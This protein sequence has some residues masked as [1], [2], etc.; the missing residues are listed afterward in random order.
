MAK[1][2]DVARIDKLAVESE[3]A[4]LDVMQSNLSFM[5]DTIIN[6]VVAKDSGLRD[7]EKLDAIKGI[8]A[9]G[10][11]AYKKDLLD[12]LTVIAYET[13]RLTKKE[14]PGVKYELSENDIY[15]VQFVESKT[16]KKLKGRPV[17]GKRIETMWSKLPAKTRKR[18]KTQQE[19]LIKTQLADLEKA[20]YFQYTTSTAQEKA[21]NQVKKDMQDAGENFIDGPSIRSGA[22]LTAH[23]V[24]N[25][26][27]NAFFT[28]PDVDE[29]IEAYEFV[30]PYTKDKTPICTELTGRIFAKDD[31]NFF[32]Y[33]PPLHWNCRSMIMPILKGDLKG[34]KIQKFTVSRKN[35]KYIQ[36]SEKLKD[37]VLEFETTI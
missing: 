14:I 13:L 27:R 35:Q 12:V 5:A 30:N 23:Q 20:L 19:L 16:V 28:D 2:K 34:R 36:F 6:K 18:L 11:N 8:K 15:S 25:D 37:F 33:T 24:V 26:A 1:Q 21:I 17:K 29:Q 31:P 22:P 3:K 9:S 10:L 4:V 7:S 32:K